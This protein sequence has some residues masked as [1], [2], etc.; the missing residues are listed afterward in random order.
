MNR[1]GPHD[2]HRGRCPVTGKI[3]YRDELA[4]LIALAD[5]QTQPGH[6]RRERRA[7]HCE[8]CRGWHL[9]SHGRS[10]W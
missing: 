9:T 5:C 8:H 7:Y 6:G 10:P 1:R 3:R 4:G 2:I